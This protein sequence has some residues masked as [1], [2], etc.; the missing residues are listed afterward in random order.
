MSLLNEWKECPALS[1]HPGSGRSRGIRLHQAG[2]RS[3]SESSTPMLGQPLVFCLAVS[4]LPCLNSHHL[5]SNA[6]VPWR[7]APYSP[8]LCSL[9]QL[10]LKG[11]QPRPRALP[12]W[13]TLPDPTKERRSRQ[14]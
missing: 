1:P 9:T 13:W 5:T 7:A 3:T 6:L 12:L 8:K 11:R 2:S 4:R 14:R 10:T